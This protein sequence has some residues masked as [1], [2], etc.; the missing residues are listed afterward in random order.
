M[1]KDVGNTQNSQGM[2][3]EQYGNQGLSKDGS[4][5]KLKRGEVN[6]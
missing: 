4:N 3:V 6:V 1:L 2:K 5:I